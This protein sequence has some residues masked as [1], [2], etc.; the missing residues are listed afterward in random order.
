MLFLSFNVSGQ[1]YAIRARQIIEVLPNL[2][3]DIKYD[4]AEPDYFAGII[5][6]HGQPLPVIDLCQLLDKCQCPNLLSSRIILIQSPFSTAKKELIGLLAEKVT[7]TLTIKVTEDKTVNQ[8]QLK[9]HLQ[10][11]LSSLDPKTTLFEAA[12]QMPDTLKDLLEHL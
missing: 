1:K 11:K 2:T 7:A 4:N 10:A 8:N 5:D 6:Y 12:D 9:K 3:N